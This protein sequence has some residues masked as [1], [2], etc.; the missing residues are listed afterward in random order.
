MRREAMAQDMHAH[1][2]VE[3]RHGR[4]QP[5]GRMQDGRVNRLVG[6]AAREQEQRRPR[7]PPVAAQDAEQRSRQ[8]HAAFLAALAALRS[9]RLA[10]VLLQHVADLPVHCRRVGAS[11]GTGDAPGQAVERGLDPAAELLV[12]CLS[13]AAPFG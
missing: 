9:V 3:P 12:D 8:H 6:R 1:G 5:A 10:S 2:L 13:F 7:Q 4:R 11:S